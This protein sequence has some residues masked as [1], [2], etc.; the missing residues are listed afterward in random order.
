LGC[1]AG[2]ELVVVGAVICV[3]IWQPDAWH[4]VLRDE[5]PEFGQLFKHLT[6]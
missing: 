6:E 4:A 5:M 2:G 1:A 3:E